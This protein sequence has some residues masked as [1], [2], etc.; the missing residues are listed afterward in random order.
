MDH[1]P[2]QKETGRCREVA[3]VQRWPLYRGGHCTGVTVSGGSTVC[4]VTCNNCIIV[5][6]NCNYCKHRLKCARLKTKIYFCYRRHKEIQ[7]VQKVY[8]TCFLSEKGSLSCTCTFMKT[9]IVSLSWLWHM[10]FKTCNGWVLFVVISQSIAG[11]HQPVAAITDLLYQIKYVQCEC[12]YAFTCQ[13]HANT[14]VIQLCLIYVYIHVFYTMCTSRKYPIP[15]T[16]HGNSERF[17]YKA[18]CINLQGNFFREF[19]VQSR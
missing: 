19:R 15:P 2:G 4:R 6:N 16:G 8:E 7:V 18:Y 5:N 12:M 13:N 17:C 14:D 9:L 1:L 10:Y 3:L 11:P